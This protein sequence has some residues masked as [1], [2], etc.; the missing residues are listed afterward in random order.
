MTDDYVDKMWGR[1]VEEEE[2]V[3]IETEKGRVYVDDPSQ[4]PGDVNVQEGNQGGYFY[5][6]DGG[7][8]G[9]GGGS[10]QAGEIEDGAYLSSH[11]NT[12]AQD[13]L[14]EIRDESD[15]PG[16]INRLAARVEDEGVE[17]LDADSLDSVEEAMETWAD[18]IDE[19]GGDSSQ[20]RESLSD[21]RRGR[22]GGDD[23]G[24]EH[25]E[26][27]ESETED[28]PDGNSSSDLDDDSGGWDGG[29]GWE[30]DGW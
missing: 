13:A 15:D 7:Q 25:E 11:T 16:A 21:I 12:F 28:E 17:N 6:T 9:G 4:A 22:G 26:S 1:I 3:S 2:V 19:Q 18:Q 23:S 30:N 10:G 20:V 5:V 27:T 8:E 14:Y 24:N 29:G